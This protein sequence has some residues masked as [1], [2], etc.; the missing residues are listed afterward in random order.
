MLNVRRV[1]LIQRQATRASPGST[2]AATEHQYHQTPRAPGGKTISLPQRPGAAESSHGST[3]PR[4]ADDDGRVPGRPDPRAGG[5]RTKEGA[6]RTRPL[7]EERGAGKRTTR[8]CWDVDG[9][10]RDEA[11]GHLISQEL[12]KEV[13]GFRSGKQ[14]RTR[15]LKITWTRGSKE[16]RGLN[17]RKM[18][19]MKRSNAWATSGRRLRNYCRAARTTPSRT[20]G[21]RPCGGTCGA[22]PGQGFK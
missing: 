15:W 11:L 9:Q 22:E 5:R 6:T 4:P 7:K 20:T 12:N 21:T 8:S 2:V 19:S 3:A 10:A 13:P 17:R 16:N 14:C 18:S 1:A